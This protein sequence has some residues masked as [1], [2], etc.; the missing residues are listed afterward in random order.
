M[1]NA[2]GKKWARKI[3][4]ALQKVV[5]EP[6]VDGEVTLKTTAEATSSIEGG[7]VITVVFNTVVSDSAG[8]KLDLK[9]AWSP[10]DAQ[11]LEDES[12]VKTG[13][14]TKYILS[15]GVKV[16]PN[17]SVMIKA[18]G[19]STSVGVAFN[20]ILNTLSYEQIYR[21]ADIVP[22]FKVI[23]RKINKYAMRK[24]SGKAIEGEELPSPKTE[25]KSLSSKIDNLLEGLR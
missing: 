23:M 14:N 11:D 6:V 10:V 12:G 24:F 21:A 13:M 9:Y 4:V 22:E 2:L 16:L 18:D 15:K 17:D 3:D 25:G 7:T 1:L 5:S 19:S 8:N 20:I